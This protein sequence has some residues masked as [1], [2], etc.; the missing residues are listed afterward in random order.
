[1]LWALCPNACERR[2]KG[3]GE[4]FFWKKKGEYRDGIKRKETRQG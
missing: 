2:K 3:K 4:K 1:M